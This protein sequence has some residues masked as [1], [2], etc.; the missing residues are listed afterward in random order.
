MRDK[1]LSNVGNQFI[2]MTKKDYKICE[3]C[4]KLIRVNEKNDHS[5]KYC[6]QCAKKKELESKRNWWNNNK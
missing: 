6:K 3:V 5:T 4:G 2:A 1:E